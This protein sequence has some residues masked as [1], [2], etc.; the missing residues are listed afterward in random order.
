MFT[1][2]KFQVPL[3]VEVAECGGCIEVR[4]KDYV[5]YENMHHR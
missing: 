3:K 1:K 4:I 2:Y 5:D